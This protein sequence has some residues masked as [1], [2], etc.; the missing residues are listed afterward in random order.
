MS[1]LPGTPRRGD[2]VR[3]LKEGSYF[4][5]TGYVAVEDSTVPSTIGVRV[6]EVIMD[7]G[8]GRIAVHVF[9]LEVIRA[10]S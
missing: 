4:N 1:P 5:R 8:A 10:A 2:Y 9:H 7:E 6:C 3:V